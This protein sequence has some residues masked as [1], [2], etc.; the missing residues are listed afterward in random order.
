[1]KTQNYKELQLAQ[2]DRFQLSNPE[3]ISGIN[4]NLLNPWFK[5][6]YL[7]INAW[8]MTMLE[9]KNI[10]IHRI[11]EINDIRFLKAIKTIL[12]EKAEDTVLVLTEA[13]KQDIIQSRKEIKD[14]LFISNEELDKEIQ[15][16]LK[17]E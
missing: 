15:A 7:C 2:L 6:S 1:M 13:Q 11:S 5:N 3:F 8:I 9:L 14:G 10:L 4:R 17:A 12:D 16:W